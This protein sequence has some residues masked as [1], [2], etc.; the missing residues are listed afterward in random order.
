MV[1][2]KHYGHFTLRQTDMHIM[3]RL[4]STP[5]LSYP[6]RCATGLLNVKVFPLTDAVAQWRSYCIFG[7]FSLFMLIL[8]SKRTDGDEICMLLSSANCIQSTH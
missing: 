6:S 3:P 1:V 2:E 4:D 5:C 7:N 8:T